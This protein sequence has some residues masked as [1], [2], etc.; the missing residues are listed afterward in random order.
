MTPALHVEAVLEVFAR[1]VRF[2]AMV[3]GGQPQPIIA[4]LAELID[5]AQ[6]RGEVRADVDPGA[7]AVTVAA[8][9]LF[10]AVQAASVGADPLPSLRTA[11]EIV[12]TG[13]A[14]RGSAHGARASSLT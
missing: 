6:Q 4:L 14:H 7:A 9:A 2:A 1:P 10:P 13:L 11:L 5:E 3:D 12:W 8:G